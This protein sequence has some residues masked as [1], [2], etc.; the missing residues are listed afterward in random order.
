MAKLTCFKLNS[1]T[2]YVLA[3]M[4]CFAANPERSDAGPFKYEFS[5]K[6]SNT[7]AGADVFVASPVLNFIVTCRTSTGKPEFNFYDG[8]KIMLDMAGQQVYVPPENYVGAGIRNITDGVLSPWNMDGTIKLQS[9]S[10]LFMPIPGGKVSDIYWVQG[11]GSTWPDL[12]REKI[13]G[14]GANNIPEFIVRNM[15]DKTRP[16]INNLSMGLMRV[17]NPSP[18]V[19]SGTGNVSFDVTARLIPECAI[20]GFMTNTQ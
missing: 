1:I 10:N 9:T 20:G 3:I 6:Y 5:S 8:G 13:T 11:T 7:A 18:G 15:F 12:G 19:S 4:L 2:R 16:Y 17:N 14:E